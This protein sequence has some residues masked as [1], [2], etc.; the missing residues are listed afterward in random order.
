MLDIVHGRLP[1]LILDARSRGR[2]EGRDPEPR[3]GIESGHMPGARSLPYTE[4][5]DDNGRFLP[6]A[7]LKEKLRD[8]A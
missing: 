8:L 6:A 1:G 2:F 5:L 3:A 4:L 7:T